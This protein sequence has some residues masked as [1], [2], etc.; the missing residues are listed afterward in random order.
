MKTLGLGM[1]WQDFSVGAR[2]RT[3][4]RSITEAE[5]T[6]FVA[7]TG[8]SEA[9]FNDLEY[10]REH[11]A[12]GG[13]AAPGALVYSIAEGLV[14]AAS[15]QRTGMAFLGMQLDVHAPTLAGDTLHVEVEVTEARA[16]SRGERGLVRTTNRVMKQ[17]G[18]CVLTYTPLRMVRGRARVQE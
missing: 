12:L 15:L 16:A 3:L 4:S 17:D 9:L 13:R 2:F 18:T 5:I 10:I 14:I 8:M 1:Y 7:V 11:S 6:T